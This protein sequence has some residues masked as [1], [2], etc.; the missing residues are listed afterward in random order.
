MTKIF[1]ERVKRESLYSRLI[2]TLIKRELNKRSAIHNARRNSPMAVFANDWIGITIS[3]DGIYEGEHLS[4]L[5]QILREI[6]V[7][8][9]ASSAIDI[10]ANIGNHS[11]EFS[12]HFSNVISFEPNPRTFDI[13]AANT[14]H[15][16]NVQAH[17]WGCSSSTEKMKFQ[18]D[19]ENIGKS[20]S[21]MAI[22]ADNEIEIL[23]KPLDELHEGLRNVALIKIDVE[24]M[25]YS[26][27]K[28][29]ERVISKFRPVICFEQHATEFSAKF[30]ETASIDWLR[31]KG[32]KLFAL[33]Q[34]KR[35]NLILKRLNNIKQLFFG[36]TEHRVIVEY[37]RF[38]KSTFPMIYAVH[39][40][41][42]I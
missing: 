13:L 41:R 26:A 29:A 24:G 5:F 10:G 3:V 38:P 4:D 36:I 35:R 15:L 27:L 8:T 17:N 22:A 28:G 37:E 12:K 33:A 9:N 40:S 1:S 23:V 25:E 31:Y 30:N 6:D 19:F 16:S 21:A 42:L 7:D 14:K 34:S 2:G 20:S 11:I 18:E 39:A 32:Y